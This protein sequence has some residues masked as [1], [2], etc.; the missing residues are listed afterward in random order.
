[1]LPWWL[2]TGLQLVTSSWTESTWGPPEDC[3]QQ[4]T[5]RTGGEEVVLLV[6]L[7][8]AQL[9]PTSDDLRTLLLL[10]VVVVLLQ[11]LSPYFAHWFLATVQIPQPAGPD[12]SSCWC[13]LPGFHRWTL[14]LLSAHSGNRL[15]WD[16]VVGSRSSVGLRQ[17]TAMGSQAFR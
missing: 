16:V 17:D 8:W 1:M 11:E 10:R 2:T 14:A 4:H 13:R 15:A 7:K 12:P 3:C 9:F 5:R 6:P